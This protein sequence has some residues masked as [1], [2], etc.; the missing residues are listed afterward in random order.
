VNTA[1]AE[2]VELHR[3]RIHAHCYRMLGSVQD[4]EDA[5]QETLV[6]AWK[7]IDG[8]QGRSELSTWLHTIA[9]RV[10][11][12]MG[13]RRPRLLSSDQGPP[14]DP[15]A[16]LPE[17][18]DESWWVEP[19]L[20]DASVLGAAASPEAR[21]DQHESVEVAFVA[22]L[23][24]LPA[25]QRAVL[26][27][28]EVLGLPAA[29]VAVALDSTVAS[30]NS[31]L[32]R[33]RASVGDRLPAES[34]RATIRSVGEDRTQRL[35]ERF[36]S[37]W[38]RADVDGMVALLAE[39]VAFTMPPLPTWFR[40]RDDAL[41]FWAER[42][43]ATPWRPAAYP[44]LAQP[45]VA[46]YRQEDDGVFRLATLNVLEVR[47]AD[48]PGTDGVELVGIRAFLGAD[49]LTHLGLPATSP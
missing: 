19:Y 23:Q 8:F 43:F 47:P 5:T 30:V 9:T 28:R 38:E 6:A 49:V 18:L 4:A 36:V 32:Q 37:A 14:G 13:Q 46:S 12:R 33:A 26:I 24:H 20:A 3:P 11:I 42:V 34:Q 17:P 44:G 2:L 25:S 31:A 27:L 7:G 16:A 22:A 45:A 40:G 39:D 21:Y 41:T 1:F 35:V 29:D 15:R 10:C 48:R